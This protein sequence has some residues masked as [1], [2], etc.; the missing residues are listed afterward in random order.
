MVSPQNC[1]S[2]SE[3]HFVSNQKT[4][5]FNRVV[6]SINVVSQEKVIGVRNASSNFEELD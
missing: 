4:H 1:E 2:V 3:A 6:A 5:S